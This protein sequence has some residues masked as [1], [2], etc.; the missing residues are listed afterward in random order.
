VCTVG[1]LSVVY[2]ENAVYRFFEHIFIGIATGFGAYI[3]VVNVLWPR[4]FEL[5]IKKGHW[6]WAFTIV[7]GAMWYFIFSRKHF[8][9]SR[10]IQQTL[11]GLGAG[12]LFKG[13]A[14]SNMAKFF[15]SM[16]PL[17]G[18]SLPKAVLVGETTKIVPGHP[19]SSGE[20]F[21]HLIFIVVLFTV[22]SYFFFSF[23]H[24]NRTVVRTT[25]L[26][27]FFLMFTFGAM[28]GSTV[29]ARLS[30]LIGRMDFLIHDWFVH[31]RGLF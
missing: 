4:C 20:V 7:A 23:E 27:R 11:M 24:K 21:S 19:L 15:A 1:I 3:T 9:I 6:Y 18:K 26:G 8:W 5:M 13:F 22:M 29:M 31:F 10:M 12:W 14:S 25:Q 30:L 2:R 28:F 16:K 17:W